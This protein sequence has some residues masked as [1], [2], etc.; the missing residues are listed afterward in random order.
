M[1][2][3]VEGVLGKGVTAKDLVL[4]VI[5]KMVPR[6]NRYAMEFAAVRFGAV[7]GRKDD[8]MQHGH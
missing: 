1:L 6:R 8:G 5:G 3:L 7:H 4:A 2:V